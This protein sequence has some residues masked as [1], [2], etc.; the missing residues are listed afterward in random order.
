[1]FS[2]I[3]YGCFIISMICSA[4]IIYLYQDVA[5]TI[6]FLFMG[7][8]SAFIARA[9]SKYRVIIEEQ[10][11]TVVYNVIKERFQFQK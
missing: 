8:I 6:L 2:K 4:V 9:I 3:L 7:I 5:I 11:L 10:E 1:M